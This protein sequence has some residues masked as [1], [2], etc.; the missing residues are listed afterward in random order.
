MEKQ[1]R[2][3]LLDVLRGF[4]II[5][6]LGTNIWLFTHPG[7]SLSMFIGGDSGNSIF[8]NLQSVFINGKFLGLLTILFGI[9]LELKYRKTLRSQL[10]WLPV[11][12]WT[13]VILFMDGLLHYLFVFDY[14]ILMSYAITGVIVAFIIRYREKVVTRWMR[15]TVAIHVSGV[16][17]VT[18]SMIFVLQDPEFLTMMD[19]LAAGTAD[20]YM[21]GTYL[22]QIQYRLIGFGSLRMEAIAIL[23]MNMFLYL[24]G[25]RLMR[26]GAFASDGNGQ[27]IRRK[28][29]YWGVGVGL[30][31]NLLALVP[32]GYFEIPV[33][34]LFA[35]VLSV[36]YIGLIAW[37]MEAG[38]LR[39]FVKRFEAIGQTALSCYVLQNIVASI[40]FYSWGFQLA[41]IT[42]AFGTFIA[43]AGITILMMFISELFMK[44]LGTGPLEWVW[45]RLSYRP[46]KK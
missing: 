8:E 45:R 43:F 18:L 33:R 21:K 26:A 36:G 42:G 41:P 46:F 7:D 17:F 10:P 6:T 2:I 23:F 39:W 25:I 9:G 12:I 40:L 13:M 14:D 24:F 3:R 1:S 34:Y 22:E 5:G 31:L 28:L 37:L 4:A 19:H 11:Y 15:V 35:P 44:F 30:P 32:G 38:V 29:L 16:L 20:I 27:R